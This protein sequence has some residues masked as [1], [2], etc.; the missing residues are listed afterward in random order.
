[1]LSLSLVFLESAEGSPLPSSPVVLPGDAAFRDLPCVLRR[2]LCRRR[3]TGLQSLDPGG[4]EHNRYCTTVMRCARMQPSKAVLISV[5]GRS[6]ITIQGTV[7][8]C[9][10]SQKR[11]SWFYADLN[12]EF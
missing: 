2:T 4:R 5:D 10:E 3:W 6:G 1:M 11:T 7:F 8:V 9:F 12:A